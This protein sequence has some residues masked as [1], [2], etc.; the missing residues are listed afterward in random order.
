MPLGVVEM[1]AH[2]WRSVGRGDHVVVVGEGDLVLPVT[3]MERNKHDHP[4]FP[5][6]RS[7]CGVLPSVVFGALRR[8]RAVGM[9][10]CARTRSDL[11]SLTCPQEAMQSTINPEKGKWPHPGHR[12]F[13]PGPR[14]WRQQVA[15][16]R[17]QAGFRLHRDRLGVLFSAAWIE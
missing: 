14:D 13:I 2:G 11:S 17:R 7:V 4:S 12:W 15:A 8:K 6:C 10:C 16:D 3:R 5:S 1:G 9:D